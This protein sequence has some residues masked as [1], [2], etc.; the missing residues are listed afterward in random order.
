MIDLYTAAT[1]NGHKVSIALEELG[2]PYTLK[3]LDLAKGEQKTPAFL[4]INPRG[5]RD[6]AG[7]NAFVRRL[8]EDLRCDPRQPLQARRF[9][10]SITTLQRAMAGEEEMVRVLEE[11]GIDPAS[12]DDGDA[13]RLVILRHTLMN[14]YLID[15]E[16][17]ISYIDLYFEHL[18]TRL[19]ELG[20]QA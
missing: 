19:A 15:H 10:A 9:F 18:A 6:L 7:A 11:L 3:V 20:A 17:S 2:L 1:P 4:A 16:N 13:D 14:P 12:M 5:N 8:Y